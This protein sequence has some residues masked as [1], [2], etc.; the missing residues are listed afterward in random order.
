[1]PIRYPYSYTLSLFGFIRSCQRTEGFA[2]TLD[3]HIS[4]VHSV[5]FLNSVF[6]P[7][8]YM[9]DKIEQKRKNVSK[10]V[11]CSACIIF[12]LLRRESKKKGKNKNGT[13]KMTDTE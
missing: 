11:A 10:M 13:D 3:A 4:F 9:S 12:S 7:T 8:C 1:M 5:Y 6:E 2:F